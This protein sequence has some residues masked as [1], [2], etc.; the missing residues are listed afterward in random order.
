MKTKIEQ[1]FRKLGETDPLFFQQSL[2]NYFGSYQ[3]EQV[4][5]S[6]L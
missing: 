4:S 1:T 3:A 6:Y 2:S 5:L